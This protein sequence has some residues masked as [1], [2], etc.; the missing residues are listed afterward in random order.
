MT[1]TR[2]RPL[3]P[4]QELLWE[5][6]SG[7]CPSDPAGS[8]EVAYGCRRLRGRLDPETL[9]LAMA[10]VIARQEALRV[11]FPSLGTDPRQRVL[12]H[13][14]PPLRVVDLTGAAEPTQWRTVRRLVHDER[15]E[16][17]DLRNGPL[18]RAQLMRLSPV[19]HVLT[20]TFCHLIADGWSGRVFAEEVVGA[21]RAR[22]GHGQPLPAKVP[23]FLDL[24]ELRRPTPAEASAR[25]AYWRRQLLPLPDYLPFPPLEVDP[26]TDVAAE[27]AVPFRFPPDVCQGLRRLA[28][29][30]RTTPYVVLLAA[31]HVLLAVRTGA[32]RVVIGTTTLGRD[33]AAEKRVIGQFTN[34][35]YVAARIDRRSSLRDCVTAVERALDEAL[36]HLLPYQT[37]AAAIRPA[38]AHERPWPDNHLFHSYFQAAPAASPVLEFPEL[39]VEEISLSGEPAPGAPAALRARDVPADQLRVW[40]KR[41]API[42]IV[43]DDRGG[44]VLVHNPGFFEESLVKGLVTDYLRIVET[45]VRAPDRTVATVES[46]EEKC[47]VW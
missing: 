8:R 21:Y 7:L 26:E 46:E 34:D 6:M 38:F 43:D 31:Y 13:L 45:I 5:F 18:W 27:R 36:A 3:V 40:L 2:E 28:W 15:L 44:G 29:R 30:L 20:F 22:S 19:D 23:S 37:L 42:V 47:R 12:P 33:T 10:D 9:R 39:R 1:L 17:F 32:E 16:P 24:A 11:V 14:E 35:L 4:S 25:A 41:G